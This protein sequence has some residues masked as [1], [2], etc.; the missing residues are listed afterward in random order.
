MV[1]LTNIQGLAIVTE[2][3]TS[4]QGCNLSLGCDLKEVCVL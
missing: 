4:A 3:T 2:I 1:R